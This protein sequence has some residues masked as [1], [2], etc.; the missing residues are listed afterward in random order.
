M[1]GVKFDEFRRSTVAY[2]L[3]TT[4]HGKQ[5][6]A[7]VHGGWGQLDVGKCSITRRLLLP[8]IKTVKFKSQFSINPQ[9]SN[10]SFL[11]MIQ[12]N[13]Q[14]LSLPWLSLSQRKFLQR[15]PLLSRNSDFSSS[16][17][18]SEFIDGIE[19]Q[20]SSDLTHKTDQKLK[21]LATHHRNHLNYK[22]NK[23][24]EHRQIYRTLITKSFIIR[25]VI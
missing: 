9:S 14:R 18:A 4:R 11:S 7:G 22:I 10:F 19:S 24:I 21:D 3:K 12:D 8:F 2:I 15:T 20:L 17:I 5:T 23:Y 16:R 25:H 1:K 13:N 6:P